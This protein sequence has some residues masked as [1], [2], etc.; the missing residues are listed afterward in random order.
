MKRILPEDLE[1]R[2]KE[3]EKEL[4]SSRRKYDLLLNAITSYVF[5]VYIQDGKP[6]STEHGKT[7][8]G[9]TGYSKKE[10][11]SDPHLW[12]HMVHED[13]R[14]A[15]LLHAE[16]ILKEKNPESIEHRIIH[17]DGHIIW[18]RKTVIPTYDDDGKLVAYDGIIEDISKR[19]KS[20]LSLIES[21][22]RSMI[23]NDL[24]VKLNK[25][26]SLYEMFKPLL[27]K[28]LEICGMS[29]GMVYSV[30]GE[31]AVCRY[32]SGLP[33]EFVE[34]TKN[35]PL[36]LPDVKK[37]LRSKSPITVD[38]FTEEYPGTGRPF[39]LRHA[40]STPLKAEKE[41]VGFLNVVTHKE[42]KDIENVKNL[43][44]ML[45]LEAESFFRKIMAEEALRESEEQF[46]TIFETTPDSITINK[47]DDG[48]YVKANKGFTQLTDYK[49][50]EVVGRSSLDVK[51][52]EEPKDRDRLVKALDKSGTVRNLEMNFVSKRGKIRTTLV[53]SKIINLNNEP[54]ILS[55]TRNIEDRLRSEEAL[56]VKEER[57][58][59]LFDKAYDAITFLDLSGKII[60]TNRRS[61][62]FLEGNR[63]ELIGKHFT[64][65]GVLS[66]KDIPRMVKI[67]KQILRGEDIKAE[68]EIIDRK[69]VTKHLEATGGLVKMDRGK[70]GIMIISRDITARVLAEREKNALQEQLFQAQKLESIG[71]LAGGIAHDFNNILTGI[72]GYAELLKLQFPEPESDEGQAADVI[73]DG[74]ERAANLT[75][76]LLGFA[77]GGK[78][79]PEVLNINEVL[80]E[81]VSI[82]EKNL[83]NRIN[84]KFDLV[85][86]PLSVRAD[87]QQLIQILTNLIINSKD[88][89][90]NG[91]EISFKTENI[92]QMKGY[93]KVFPSIKKGDYIKITI[94]DTGMGMPDDVRDH[95]FEPFFTTK[96]KGK[97]T[98]LGLATV[99]GIIKNHEGFIFCDSKPGKGTEFTIFLPAITEK[100]ITQKQ[101]PK[102]IKGVATI[103][104]VDD[105]K[106]VR[107]LTKA[108]LEKIGYKVISAGDGPEAIEIFKKHMN[109]IDIVLLDVVMPGMSGKETFKALKK[110]KKDI[111][112][113]LVSG[114]SQENY[115][116]E[117]A[118][119]DISAFLQ[120]PFRLHEISDLLQKILRKE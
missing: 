17:K 108:Q 1:K 85:E 100:I 94:T 36:N 20:E 8:L 47:Y 56:R 61:L 120:K 60:E 28:A 87:R 38:S 62:D 18:I 53:S 71:R 29:S 41:V 3:K 34:K 27:D 105:E 6:G 99:Y 104:A 49:E 35:M 24:L 42:I 33:E 81:T 22:S 26:S 103:L 57:F 106:H 80:Q 97:G 69:G 78:Y 109:K 110:L 59:N 9:I 74:T 52:W 11:D 79:N 65:L 102:T 46:R 70:T 32:H 12:I 82:S 72:M 93:N 118:S 5:T 30:E 54:H 114:Y 10:F 66:L 19:K 107:N 88:A 58:R 43:L 15:V 95:V 68:L 96:G 31:K 13:D 51:I 55:I 16:S 77:R 111:K 39:G 98:G 73:I 89:M 4:E 25:C 63:E 44:G 90:P 113:V 48:T 14:K 40:F 119:E 83:D 37:V 101:T 64:K 86:Q 67:F 21:A 76:Q 91:G 75:Q 45:A 50:E 115:S 92:I 2:L 116:E 23:M 117:I 7:C 112:V 84:I